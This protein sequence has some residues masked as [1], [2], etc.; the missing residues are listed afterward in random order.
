MAKIAAR[1]ASFY[2]EDSTGAC[3]ALSARTSSISLSYTAE[4]PEVTGFGDDNRQ[5]LSNGIKDWEL[6]FEGFYD[7]AAGQ[8]DTVL[9][10]ILGGSTMFKM[11]P[12][13]S[14]TTCLMYSG[15]GI[16]MD[17]SIDLGVEDAVT[18]S[19]TV[20]ARSGSL[21]RVASGTWT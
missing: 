16:L 2:L 13:G 6:T 18:V 7:A 19:C 21:T 10:S 20:A 5:R 1:N 4:T 12:A 3:Q 15:C 11:G 9:S 17:Y 14:A 8:V